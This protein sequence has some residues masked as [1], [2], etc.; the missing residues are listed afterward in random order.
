[1]SLLTSLLRRCGWAPP[2]PPPPPPETLATPDP[3]DDAT[4]Q[5]REQEWSFLESL[6]GGTQD[7]IEQL[8]TMRRVQ[9][10]S[11]GQ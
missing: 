6:V 10:R 8:R 7:R 11:R 5:T 3:P 4:R 1:V 9:E 2:S